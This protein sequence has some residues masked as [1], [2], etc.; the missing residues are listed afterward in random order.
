MKDKLLAA[1]ILTA[2]IAIAASLLAG[3]HLQPP[4]ASGQTLPLPALVP[5]LL[6]WLAI[7]L[8]AAYAH[9]TPLADGLDLRRPF[10]WR[11]AGPRLALRR[12]QFAAP[13]H[14]F[15]SASSR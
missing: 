12:G 5:M 8:I 3:A 10:R 9:V 15:F 14:H 11:G 2:T 13:R 4:S 7:L 6:R 1:A